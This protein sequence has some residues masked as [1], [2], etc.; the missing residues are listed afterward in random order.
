MNRPPYIPLRRG[1][2]RQSKGSAHEEVSACDC[3]RFRC[4][5]E[6]VRA[7]R[8]CFVRCVW[9]S[10]PSDRGCREGLALPQLERRLALRRRL[11][12]WPPLEPSPL[13]L[14]RLGLARPAPQPL[15][16]GFQGLVAAQIECPERPLRGP[17]CFLAQPGAKRTLWK[18]YV[19]NVAGAGIAPP[20]LIYS[21][22]REKERRNI[23]EK[24]RTCGRDC[25][26]DS[27][28]S[29]RCSGRARI[30][31]RLWGARSGERRCREGVALPQLERRLALRRRGRRLGWPQPLLEPSPPRFKPL[32]APASSIGTAPLRGR[33]F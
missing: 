7:G 28:G 1:K 4:A 20:R 10:E 16:L 23:H 32:V 33:F 26:G 30:F 25:H 8:P 22:G 24:A 15:A 19:T 13:G 31:R 6:P 14:W 11:G 2:E 5:F 27:A 12:S 17:F 9:G 18:K 3:I 21:A 29:F